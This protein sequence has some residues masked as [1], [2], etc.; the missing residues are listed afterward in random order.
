MQLQCH[1][2][3][4]LQLKHLMRY[5]LCRWYLHAR[6]LTP[7]LEHMHLFTTN[8]HACSQL[9]SLLVL[10]LD[11]IYP[12]QVTIES[13]FNSFHMHHMHRSAVLKENELTM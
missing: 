3:V 6:T 8:S 10:V 5:Q 11:E 1:A 2:V 4:F 13:E 9:A 12:L 7:Q